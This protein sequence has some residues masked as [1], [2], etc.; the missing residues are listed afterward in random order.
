MSAWTEALKE[1]VREAFGSRMRASGHP[2]RQMSV[3]AVRR[4]GTDN[5]AWHGP[6]Q[7]GSIPPVVRHGNVSCSVTGGVSVA[8]RVVPRFYD[9]PMTRRIGRGGRTAGRRT[10]TTRPAR[11]DCPPTPLTP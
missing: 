8:R 11:T 10:Q 3:T 7:Y 6:P 9:L 5:L 2:E 1:Q 4:F